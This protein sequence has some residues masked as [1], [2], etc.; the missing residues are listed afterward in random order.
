MQ[1]SGHITIWPFT[2][3]KN[4]GALWRGHVDWHQ[5]GYGGNGEQEDLLHLLGLLLTTG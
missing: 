4:S 5:S 1:M 2:L 3:E